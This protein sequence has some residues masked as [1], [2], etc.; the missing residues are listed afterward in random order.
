VGVWGS[1]LNPLEEK[2]VLFTA[3]PSFPS[4]F[5]CRYAF[6]LVFNVPGGIHGGSLINSN[7]VFTDVR[8]RK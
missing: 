1:I 4:I 2:Y 5:I 3:E 6:Y 8:L 7:K